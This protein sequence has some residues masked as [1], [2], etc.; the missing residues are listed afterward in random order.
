MDQQRILGD[1][2]WDGELLGAAAL[3]AGLPGPVP[4][5]SHWKGQ[6]LKNHVA[7]RLPAFSTLY[8]HNSHDVNP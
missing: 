5:S 6:A 1:T 7:W 8:P 2:Q 4:G 3:L